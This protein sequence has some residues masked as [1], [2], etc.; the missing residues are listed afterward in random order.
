MNIDF[1]VHGLL[2]KRKDFNEKFFLNEIKYAKRNSIDG[3]ILCEHFNAISFKI[4]YNYLEYLLVI[5][6]K[7][8]SDN[9]SFEFLHMI[10][11][12]FK[13]SFK[14]FINILK[15]FNRNWSYFNT[16]FRWIIGKV[17]IIEY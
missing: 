14:L 9:N 15:R 8:K 3:I 16:I 10:I 12:I 6:K 17:I 11:L 1:H 5:C 13:I 2:S 4:I 7:L